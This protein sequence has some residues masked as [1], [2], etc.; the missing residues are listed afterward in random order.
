MTKGK[1]EK[2]SNMMNI[3]KYR[4]IFLKQTLVCLLLML[5]GAECVQAQ[6]ET[7]SI[8]LTSSYSP[9][10]KS[11]MG[12]TAFD[13]NKV[14]TVEMD[15]SGCTGTNENVLSIGR[16]ISDWGTGT[17]GCYQIHC[18]YTKSSNELQINLIN[19]G[20]F[21]GSPIRENS[22]DYGRVTL[23]PSTINPLIIRLD[24]D[25]LY[26]NGDCVSQMTDYLKASILTLSEFQVGSMQGT[27]RSRATYEAI[28]VE[29][30]A[31]TSLSLPISNY[32]PNG[33]DF[34][35]TTPLDETKVIEADIDL[36]TCRADGNENIFS[37]GNNI[38]KWQEAGVR[39]LHLYYN[40]QTGKLTADWG[41]YDDPYHSTGDRKIEFVKDLSGISHLKVE[42]SK[43]GLFINGRRFDD[44]TT[45]KAGTNTYER[46]TDSQWF[47]EHFAKRLYELSE[48]QIG[49]QEGTKRS[50]ATYNSISVRNALK[51]GTL[52]WTNLQADGITLFQTETPVDFN[53]QN[54]EAVIDLSKCIQYEESSAESANYNGGNS[55]QTLLSV[56]TN[57]AVFGTSSDVNLHVYFNPTS[58][59]LTA[60]L[61]NY[62][63]GGSKKENSQVI[64]ASNQTLTLKISSDGFY[65]NDVRCEDISNELSAL[66]SQTKIQVGSVQGDGFR[67]S[68]L[69][70]SVQ[71]VTVAEQKEMPIQNYASSGRSFIAKTAWG[72]NKVLEAHL[73]LSGCKNAGENVLSVGNDIEQRG[74]N[75]SGIYNLHFYYTADIKRL[76]VDFVDNQYYGKGSSSYEGYRYSNSKKEEGRILITDPSNVHIALTRDGLFVDGVLYDKL[77]TAMAAHFWKLAE[78]QIGSLQGDVRSNAVYQSVEVRDAMTYGHLPWTDIQADGLMKFQTEEDLDFSKQYLE[79]EIDLSKCTVH[80]N[81][82]D[83]KGS[84][85]ETI[86]SIG[87]NIAKFGTDDDNNLHFYYN[88]STGEVTIDLVNN[89][90]GGKKV[91]SKITIPTTAANRMLKVKLGNDGLYV[92]GALVE[93]V[94]VALAP[95]LQHK[96]FQIGS[97]QGNGFRSSAYY[98]RVSIETR[99]ETDMI[100]RI[101]LPKN[102]YAPTYASKKFL[103]SLEDVDFGKKKLMVEMDLSTC[104]NEN[105]NVL[106][107][108]EQIALWGDRL[109][110]NSG[111]E[112]YETKATYSN[113]HIY[114]KPA[115]KQLEVNLVKNGDFAVNETYRCTITLTDPFVKLE[116]SKNGMIINDK[117]YDNLSGNNM[118]FLFEDGLPLSM[119]SLQGNVRSHATYP[120]LE[121]VDLSDEDLRNDYISDPQ[122]VGENKENGHATYIPYATTEDMRSDAAF[123]NR[124]WVQPD[125]AKALVMNLNGMWK[126]NYVPGTKGGPADSDFFGADFDDSS[127]QEIRVPLS[128]EMAGYGRPV[129]TNIG[130]PFKDNPPYAMESCAETQ[131]TD[132]NAIGF[133]RRSFTLPADWNGRRVFVHFDG[134]A[135]AA[136]VWV[137]GQYIGYSEGSNNDA[138]FE[139]TKALA[140]NGTAN[141][142]SVRVYRWC[143]G[144]YLEGQ[145]MWHL[146]GIHRD[147]YLVATPQVFI[148]DHVITTP[149]IAD[150]AT[151]ADL[152]V[153]VSVDNRGLTFTEKTIKVTLLD[154]TNK[155]IKSA[156]ANYTDAAN[157]VIPVALSGLK[158]LQAWSAETPYLYT[159]E[160]SLADKTTGKEE[161]AF[162]T[163]YGFRNI[164]I[165]GAQLKI[166]G[167][168]VF[169]KGVN[170]QDA[171]PE[172]GHAIDLET[173]VK[174]VTMMKRA[175]INTYRTSHYP[176]QPKMYALFDAYGLYVV[177]EADVECHKHPSLSNDANWKTAMTDRTERMVLRDRNHAGIVMWSL[178]NESG[179]G[180]NFAETY[181]RCKALDDRPVHYE[182]T[183]NAGYEGRVK[184]SDFYSYMYPTVGAVK[185]YAASTNKDHPRFLCEYAHAMGQAVG[186]LKEYWDV[187]EGSDNFIGGCI[188]DWADQAIYNVDALN[189]GTK[190]KN[191]FHYWMA[192]YDYNTVNKGNGFEGNFLN[193][194]LVTPDRRWTGKLTEVKKV[195][196]NVAF[197][198]VADKEI[199]IKN[200]QAFADLTDLTLVYRILKDG[201]I[202]EEG[203]TDLPDIAAGKTGSV[204]LPY[205]TDITAQDAE[206]ALNVALRLKSS[207]LWAEAGY[208]TADEQFVFTNTTDAERTL[209]THQS[210]GGVLAVSGNTVTGTSADGTAFR[211]DFAAD[212]KL[213]SWTYDGKPLIAAGPD[214][215]SL[216]NTDND[217]NFGAPQVKQTTTTLATALTKNADG[218]ATLT[219][220]GTASNCAYRIDYTIYPDA[221]VDMKTTFTPSGETRRLG[222]GMQFAEGFEQAEFYAKGP[223]ANYTDR[224]TGSYFGRY[225]TTIDDMIEE[226]IHPQTYGDHQGLRDLTLR[227]P[228]SR[229][230]LRVQTAGQVAF[231]LS[232]FDD[233]QWC[234]SQTLWNNPQHWYDLT[235]SAQVFAHFDYFQ[236]GLGNNSCA[237]EQALSV[238]RCPTSGNCTYTL[239]FTPNVE[240]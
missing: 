239:R 145:D 176:R 149:V 55:D 27:T 229:L 147:V 217:M 58:R 108:G 20:A 119:G 132:H 181:A 238:Y 160:V 69:Y 83:D 67:P 187:I 133:Y 116:F 157:K 109:D 177:D 35:V 77:S 78:V 112:G 54:L 120:R 16:Q 117:K 15:L 189:A 175:N 212:G 131:E 240:K 127:W 201:R 5:A 200:K 122:Q 148:R 53:A 162:S 165:D 191:G 24:K 188:W 84:K 123:Y 102:N 159:V 218:N 236:R 107:I 21:K 185:G 6:N 36:S 196:Q 17:A 25:G 94:S 72:E 138:E 154:A 129:Y 30:L 144:S 204:T 7:I 231:S 178:G 219:V 71:L 193:N 118:A 214:Y 19:K 34:M 105:E 222:L 61:V 179:G 202:V 195:Y 211:M 73:D 2:T 40:K 166:N 14:L 114:Y 230:A 51:V 194:G 150:D 203:Q 97:M 56:G 93:N 139:I 18:Y 76:E 106:S 226:Q 183:A 223:W 124:P 172:L 126:F 66:L 233:S 115:T 216:R 140:A 198:K 1:T 87:T 171:H 32:A 41:D 59:K 205:T 65:I 62:N 43:D 128:W 28:K 206:Y 170:G 88:A 237:A 192:G 12:T 101:T 85:D 47:L 75:V 37:I 151:S 74:A 11:F 64:P 232:H 121:I 143:D 210:Q 60:D 207:N 235:K 52:P 57:I 45:K 137:N 113:V 48:V 92:N 80:E 9:N 141:Q 163:K 111:Q 98:K 81:A 182:G 4:Y 221:T 99:S 23:K 227:N 82:A 103:A 8:P 146:S 197:T 213:S 13:A 104:Q 161:M 70:K 44:R 234:V 26:V 164:K 208:E 96:K 79:A 89:T 68:A 174:D 190:I 168:R 42:I 125:E 199:E 110:D 63:T 86:L 46:N 153:S 180:D 33:S 91:E 38:S 169:L 100:E 135:S 152:Q 50:Y 167:R 224:Q 22:D 29:D 186:N 136:M 209:P 156:T 90:T 49:S 173:M 155:E 10:G 215:N 228:V 130:Y 225:L 220:T 142:L 3:S 95:L 39:N 31:P 134:V 184:Y 158:G